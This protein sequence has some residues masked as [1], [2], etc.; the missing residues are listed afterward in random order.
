MAEKRRYTKRSDYWNK[1]KDEQEQKAEDLL[2]AQG[3]TMPNYKPE[4]IGESFYN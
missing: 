1:F 3:G 2:Y 4:L